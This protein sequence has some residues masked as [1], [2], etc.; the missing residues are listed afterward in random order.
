MTRRLGDLSAGDSDFERDVFHTVNNHRRRLVDEHACNKHGFQC[1]CI[2]WRVCYLQR[3]KK[4]VSEKNEGS[5]TN[6]W[7]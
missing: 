5:A 3:R 4:D 2:V 7:W 1:I 6:V